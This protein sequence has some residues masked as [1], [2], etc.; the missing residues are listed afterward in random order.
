MLQFFELLNSMIVRTD[1]NGWVITNDNDIGKAILSIAGL[2]TS[3]T[4]RRLVGIAR[5]SFLVQ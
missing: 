4:R 2:E 1:T 3:D 5:K